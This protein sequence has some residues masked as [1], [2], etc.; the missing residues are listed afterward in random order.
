MLSF[1][2]NFTKCAQNY[3]KWLF[4]LIKGNRALCIIVALS[5]DIYPVSSKYV[6]VD[7]MKSLEKVKNELIWILL[8]PFNGTLLQKQR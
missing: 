8:A 3:T 1:W 5:Q 6:I 7:I 2:H 4:H